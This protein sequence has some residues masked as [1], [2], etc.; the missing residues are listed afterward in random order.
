MAAISC[1]AAVGV[2]PQACTVTVTVCLSVI[3]SSDDG[4]GAA[5]YHKVSHRLLVCCHGR[6]KVSWLWIS[7]W[8]VC[9]MAVGVI[10]Q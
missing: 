8:W 7:Q 3:Q 4:G 2:I 10:T 5:Q 9:Y 6:C 1:C